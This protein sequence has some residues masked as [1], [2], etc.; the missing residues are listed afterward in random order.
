[1]NCNLLN[2]YTDIHKGVR[3]ALFQMMIQAGATDFTEPEAAAAT[4]ASWDQLKSLLRDHVENERA[5][6]HPLYEAKMPGVARALT[7]D[8]ETQETYLTELETHFSRLM[9]LDNPDER[10]AMGLEFYRGLSLFIA[11]YLP[12]LHR[13]EA[14]YIRNLW[15]LCTYDELREMLATILNAQSPEELELSGRFLVP[16]SNHQDRLAFMQAAADKLNPPVLEQLQRLGQELL[17]EHELE[18]L[19]RAMAEAHSLAPA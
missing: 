2:P 7:L 3:M 12:H 11:E 19:G 6:V 10:A 16:A 4:Q 14:I 15:D 18:K 8:H 5:Y 9:A 13:E 17:P 1:M